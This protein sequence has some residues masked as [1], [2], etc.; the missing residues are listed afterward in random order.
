[1]NLGTG[2]GSSVRQILDLTAEVAGRPVPHEVVGRRLGD[3]AAVYADVALAEAALGW[4]AER[5][6]AEIISSAYAWH[7]STV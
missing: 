5:T 6:L 1:M 3:P 2:V 7:A 4:R